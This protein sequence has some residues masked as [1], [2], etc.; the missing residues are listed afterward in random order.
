MDIKTTIKTLIRSAGKNDQKTAAFLGISKQAFSIFLKNDFNQ[1]NRFIKICNYCN[2]DII[3]TDH[4]NINI[5]LSVNDP[6]K[7]EKQ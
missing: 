4:E 7:T 1:V 3:I 5:T 2:C 6:E